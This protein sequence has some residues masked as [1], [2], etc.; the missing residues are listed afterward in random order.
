MK[1]K[2]HPARYLF[3]IQN[4]K[5][6]EEAFNLVIETFK[7]RNEGEIRVSNICQELIAKNDGIVIEIIPY[8]DEATRKRTG[9]VVI[10]NSY[11]EYAKDIIPHI[12]PLINVK[13][14]HK[15]K[16]SGLIATDDILKTLEEILEIEF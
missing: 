3:I 5:I 15:N 16:I 2:V 14:V 10:S 7:K 13:E 12:F 8:L 6:R 4:K 11:L 1:E 9:S